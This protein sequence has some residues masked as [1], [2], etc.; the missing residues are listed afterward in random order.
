VIGV[1]R[2]SGTLRTRRTA[3]G[4]TVAGLAVTSVLGGVGSVPAEA[5]TVTRSGQLTITPGA[6]SVA[7]DRAPLVLPFTLTA[8]CVTTDYGTAGTSTN[9]DSVTVTLVHPSSP[10]SVDSDLVFPK[11]DGTGLGSLTIY[12]YMLKGFGAHTLRA[13]DLR[14]GETATTTVVLK[15]V[16]RAS[17]TFS[18][19]KKAPAAATL[20][21]TG[22]LTAFT[23]YEFTPPPGTYA[24]VL[25]R[26]VSGRW[27]TAKSVMTSTGSANLNAKVSTKAVY[28]VCHL[29]DAQSTASCTSARSI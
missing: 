15:A 19:S 16:T 28:R 12:G 6:T 17:A 29:A 20:A 3:R 7:Y 14:T 22:K 23:G 24:L 10:A 11:D 9:C 27:V 8:P 4:L 5:E 13:T 26:Q 21:V 1:H 2:S 25:Q 18:R